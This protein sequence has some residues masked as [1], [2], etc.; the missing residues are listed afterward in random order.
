MAVVYLSLG[1]NSGDPV[2]SLMAAIGRIL[3]GEGVR[4]LGLGSFYETEPQ[5]V[6]DQP[7]FVNTAVAIKSERGPLE[8]LCCFKEIEKNMGRAEKVEGGPRVVDIDIIFHDDIILDSPGLM[9][10]HPKAAERKFALQPIVDIEPDLI[11]PVLK[12]S[13]SC[14][15]LELSGEGQGMRKVEP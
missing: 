8:L 10:P 3:A 2:G 6:K 7:W 1:S 5:G 4:P 14:L 13:V 12:K 11:H 9:I 15:L